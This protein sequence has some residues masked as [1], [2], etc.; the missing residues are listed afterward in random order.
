[1]EHGLCTFSNPSKGTPQTNKG[2]ILHMINKLF[3]LFHCH[4]DQHVETDIIYCVE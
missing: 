4:I 3:S 2:K 1:M